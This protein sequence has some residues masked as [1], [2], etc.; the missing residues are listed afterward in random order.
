MNNRAEEECSRALLGI[1]VDY[2]NKGR[3]IKNLIFHREHG[4]APNKNV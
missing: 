3:D 4:V 1:K 2:K